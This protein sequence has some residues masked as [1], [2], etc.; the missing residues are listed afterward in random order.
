M[1][2][3]ISMCNLS[4]SV[5]Y[6]MKLQNLESAVRCGIDSQLRLRQDCVS[7]VVMTS[8]P[9]NSTYLILMLLPAC[10]REEHADMAQKEDFE[11]LVVA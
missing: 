9:R 6:V 4:R 10:L 2:P 11:T 7:G 1:A 3:L 5:L 8:V